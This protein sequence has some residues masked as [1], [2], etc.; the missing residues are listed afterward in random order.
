MLK[1]H[2]I[3]YNGDGSKEDILLF[4]KKIRKYLVHRLEYKS[5]SENDKLLKIIFD[6]GLSIHIPDSILSDFTPIKFEEFLVGEIICSGCGLPIKK[7]T[8]FK[9]SFCKSRRAVCNEI[10]DAV[11][12]SKRMTGSGNSYHRLSQERKDLL[13][14][15]MSV[16]MKA[17]IESGKF[18][19]AVTNSWARSRCIIEINGK[20]IKVRSSWEAYFYIRNPSLQYEKLRVPY[21]YNNEQHLYI[22]DFVDYQHKKVYEIKPTKL[23]KSPLNSVKEQAL[24]DWTKTTDFEY[25]SI[26][27]QWFNENYD[28]SSLIGQPDEAR[29]RRLLKQFWKTHES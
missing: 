1:T 19:P 26:T 14:R 10:C 13:H 5:V 24:L 7:F 28:D 6:S 8:L 3:I 9:G 18:T 27:E 23:K 16:K 4:L 15:K 22:V 2:K 20:L 25:V 29:L 17:L 21:W 12:K 11:H